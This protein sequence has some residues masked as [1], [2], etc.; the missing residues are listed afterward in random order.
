MEAQKPYC[1]E[2]SFEFCWYL[3]M[4]QLSVQIFN[5]T[6]VGEKKYEIQ[7]LLRDFPENI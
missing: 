6:P 5:Q 7:D 3:A 4:Y 1:I 2:V